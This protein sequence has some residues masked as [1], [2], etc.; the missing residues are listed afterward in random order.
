MAELP[1][2]KQLLER[3]E[4]L[5][6][7]KCPDLNSTALLQPEVPRQGNSDLASHFTESEIRDLVMEGLV[8]PHVA[9]CSNDVQFLWRREGPAQDL[10]QAP[11]HNTDLGSLTMAA[12]GI[13]AVGMGLGAT[14]APAQSLEHQ[15]QYISPNPISQ[16]L[17]YHVG[18]AIPQSKH[19]LQDILF[20]G[21]NPDAKGHRSNGK[22]LV[23]A[24]IYG[25][26]APTTVADMENEALWAQLPFGEFEK[27][28][29]SNVTTIP[30]GLSVARK[31]GHIQRIGP[32]PV[33]A[34]VYL[35]A[36]GVHSEGKL[37]LNKAG[38]PFADGSGAGDISLT[39]KSVYNQVGLGPRLESRLYKGLYWNG[40]YA[41]I[42]SWQDVDTDGSVVIPGIAEIP[43]MSRVHGRDL[44]GL[45][46]SYSS[47]KQYLGRFFV[48]AGAGADIN[49]PKD[50]G[51]SVYLDPSTGKLVPLVANFDEGGRF[52]F[53]RVG[54][55]F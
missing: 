41:W 28:S 46:M 3:N 8:I 50:T 26:F 20:A 19:G 40:L 31:V 22:W 30:Y 10:T 47:L 45:T 9:K 48:E 34:D 23:S 4:L 17:I 32:I 36:F 51:K 7:G 42:G 27:P 49:R 18:H 38:I 54:G 29:W 44:R 43:I 2:Q 55:K 14:P 1:T 24:D 11:K 16:S 13:L 15:A 6:G 53:F 5:F 35:V 12:L 33:R 52:V 37:K 25:S 21:D 39:Q